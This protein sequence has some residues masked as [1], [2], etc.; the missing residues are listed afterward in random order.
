MNLLII[1]SRSNS[2]WVN[3]LL[4]NYKIIPLIN[5]GF[6]SNSIGSGQL[7]TQLDYIEQKLP[8]LNLKSKCNI[9]SKII[10]VTGQ[11]QKFIQKTGLNPFY[12]FT[13]L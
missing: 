10:P 11:R 13:W 7:L 6:E 12:F 2:D 9:P 3:E 5:Q 1:A 4:N 8:E